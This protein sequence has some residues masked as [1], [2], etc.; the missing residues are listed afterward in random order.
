MEFLDIQDEIILI[1]KTLSSLSIKK[2]LIAYS[3]NVIYEIVRILSL[4]NPQKDPIC[5]ITPCYDGFMKILSSNNYHTK[6]VHQSLNDRVYNLDWNELEITL[7][8][9]KVF[10]LCNPN[11]PNGYLWSAKDLTKIIEL[12]KKYE[13]L[14]VS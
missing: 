6:T 13:V 7:S 14:I 5:F 8:Q 1:L 4:F 9:S 2:D 12:C 10:L 11:N 3:P